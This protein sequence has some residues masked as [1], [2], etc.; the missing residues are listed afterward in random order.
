MLGRD[1]GRDR[2]E[3]EKDAF[4]PWVG[5]DGL[6]G[7][8]GALQKVLEVLFGCTTPDGLGNIPIDEKCL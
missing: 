2:L 7:N 1:M 8:G 4:P 5:Q 3:E 6:W